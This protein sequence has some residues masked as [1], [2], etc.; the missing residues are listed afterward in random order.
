M[1]QQNINFGASGTRNDGE[2]LF[3]AFT[4]IQA[5]F[6]ELYASVDSGGISEVVEDTSPQLGGNLD[7]NGKNITGIGN[8]NITGTGAFSDD[9]TVPDEAY[10]ATDWNASL[11]VPTKNAVRDYLEL[12]TG[13]TLPATYQPLDSDLTAIAALAPA[14]DDIVQ[15]KAG[16]WTNRTMAQLIADLSALGTTFQPLDSDLTSWAAVA[17]AAGFDTFAATPSLANLGSLLTDE[18]AGLITFMTTPSSA[19]LRSLLTD[20]SGTGVAYFQGGDIGTPSAG[21]LTNATGLPTAGLVN[22]AVTYAKMQNVSATQRALGR[23]T[24]GAGDVEEVTASQLLDW[25]GSTRGAIL[26]RGAAGWAILAPGTS[27][28]V[29]TSNGAGADPS[30]A[31]SSGS[32]GIVLLNSGSVSAAATLDIVLT[33]YTSYRGLKIIL[34]NFVPATDQV[35]LLLR[36]ST[37]GGSTYD[38]GASDYRFSQFGPRSGAGATLY[39]VSDGAT[40]I[41]IG[42]QSTA[43]ATSNVAGEGGM[44]AV[45]EIFDQ[46]STTTRTKAKFDAGYYEATAG[47]ETINGW[48]VRDAAQ[49]TDA[50]RFLFSS[51]NITS[52]NWAIYGYA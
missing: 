9:V 45:I 50:I 24:A 14:N 49:D 29:L 40:A 46:T 35:G 25:V 12:L 5:N 20:E 32:G 22:D 36:F 26:Y 6:D 18:A 42:R 37:D 47:L 43:Q 41:Q 28:H 3:S 4:K 19:N 48:G 38:A 21:V 8:I 10:N 52:G 16:A 13:T 11:E 39:V 44:N 34:S 33:S 27:G 23:N 15:R 51:G 31:A 7:L 17:R 2:T 30:Y 1:T